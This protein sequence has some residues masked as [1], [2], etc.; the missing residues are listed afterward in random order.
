MVPPRASRRVDLPLPDGPMMASIRPGSAYPLSPCKMGCVPSPCKMGCV[1]FA[2]SVTI[3][4]K[5]F[6]VKNIPFSSACAPVH[7]SGRDAPWPP[8]QGPHVAVMGVWSSGEANTERKDDQVA[9]R[10]PAI[11]VYF[12]SRA[13]HLVIIAVCFLGK[14]RGDEIVGLNSESTGH[15]DGR[16]RLHRKR[17][18]FH[19]R[20]PPPPPPLSSL[21]FL[22]AVGLKIK[23]MAMSL[24][25]L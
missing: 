18:I 15:I 23:K 22:G 19:H 24:W 3:T 11:I 14:Q 1:P 10:R 17:R 8:G 9:S 21:S 12:G 16:R 20:H 13:P 6:H 5:S 4:H 2:R 25:Y 7:R